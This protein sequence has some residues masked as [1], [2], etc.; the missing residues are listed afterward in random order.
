[1][2]NDFSGFLKDLRSDFGS[3]FEMIFGLISK[4]V[5][6]KLRSTD[7]PRRVREAKRICSSP[8]SRTLYS[9][10]P[11]RRHPAESLVNLNVFKVVFKHFER[12][13]KHLWV[14]KACLMIFLQN[15]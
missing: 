7:W 10:I 5:L 2:F 12:I 13:S 11:G 3:I 9:L 1:M 8:Q 14:F 6:A 4:F 15:V